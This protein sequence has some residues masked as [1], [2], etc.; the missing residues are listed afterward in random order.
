MTLLSESNRPIL[1]KCRRCEHY[2]SSRK[3]GSREPVHWCVFQVFDEVKE[4]PVTHYINID[5]LQVCPKKV[6]TTV[7]E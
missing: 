7:K 5:Y 4:R 1:E 6:N 3:S 2:S